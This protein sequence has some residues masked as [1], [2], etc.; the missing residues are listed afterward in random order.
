MATTDVGMTDAELIKQLREDAE[1]LRGEYGLTAAPANMELAAQRLA[2]DDLMLLVPYPREVKPRYE[3]RI[4]K[5][6][7]YFH[8]RRGSGYDMPL[9]EVLNTLN[10]YALRKEQLRW[11]VETYGE[12]SASHPSA[13][14]EE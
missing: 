2:R 1:F 5:F 6:G 4:G 8:D 3:L 14:P 10:R 9:D 13:R 11:Y 12:P 7:P